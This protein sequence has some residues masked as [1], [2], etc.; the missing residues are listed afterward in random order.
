MK[1]IY[2]TN[3]Q[4]DLKLT[5]T[6]Q[7]DTIVIDSYQ[8]DM[9]ESYRLTFGKN[10]PTDDIIKRI[11]EEV[12]SWTALMDDALDELLSELDNEQP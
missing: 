12:W 2:N 11:G 3:V 1:S 10:E 7:H 6:V 4:L 5:I 9:N 8:P